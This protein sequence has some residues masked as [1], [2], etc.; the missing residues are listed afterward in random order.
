MARCLAAIAHITGG[1]GQDSRRLTP[2]RRVRGGDGATRTRGRP[3]MTRA[4]G[5]GDQGDEGGRR[6]RVRVRQPL[7]IV[8]AEDAKRNRVFV[9]E[10]V[11]GGN[12]DAVG[13]I[14][15]GDVLVGCSAVTLK[16]SKMSGSFEKEGYGARPYDN[17]QEIWVDCRRLKFDTIMAALASNNPR[18][19]I[20]SI[21][22]ELESEG[23]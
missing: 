15:V 22:L 11:P 12:A 9:E 1:A 18:W 7:G 8:L 5:Q 3:P 10:I 6:Y 2:T 4:S 17:W 16:E 14:A 19:G 21:E 20:F 23:Q 13:G